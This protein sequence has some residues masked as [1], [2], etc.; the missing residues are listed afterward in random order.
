VDSAAFL[1]A[2]RPLAMEEAASALLSDEACQHLAG[3]HG[4]YADLP[5]WDAASLEDATKAYAEQQAIKL[6][7]IAQPL[8]AALTGSRTSPGIYDVLAALGREESL[9]RISDQMAR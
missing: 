9:G 5:T 6:G 3:L 2:Q 8:R 1:F 4:A 7:A